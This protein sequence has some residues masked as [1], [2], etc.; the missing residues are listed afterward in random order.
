MV[1]SSFPLTLFTA[2]RCPFSNN[3][4]E[5]EAQ[6]QGDGDPREAP[7]GG[8]LQ[9]DASQGEGDGSE[10][11]AA[12]AFAEPQSAEEHIEERIEIITERAFEDPPVKGGPDV[13]KP[14]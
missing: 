3:T 7:D 2:E 9:G 13:E 1:Q 12:V 5:G 10:L 6:C 8:D 14:I 4:V 11:H